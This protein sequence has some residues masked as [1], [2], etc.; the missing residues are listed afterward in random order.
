VKVQL[1]R[2]LPLVRDGPRLE[3]YVLLIEAG[4]RTLRRVLDRPL[5]DLVALLHHESASEP[6]RPLLGN[7]AL[8]SPQAL[9]AL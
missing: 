5:Q 9:D 4:V 3:R 6:A 2:S 8:L 1:V 7:V